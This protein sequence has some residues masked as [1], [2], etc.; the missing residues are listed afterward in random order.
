MRWRLFD[1]MLACEPGV[2]ATAGRKAAARRDDRAARGTMSFLIVMAWYLIRG[3]TAHALL[4][5]NFPAKL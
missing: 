3:F 1:E 5:G 2:S 4:I